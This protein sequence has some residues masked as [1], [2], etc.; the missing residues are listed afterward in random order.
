MKKIAKIALATTLLLTLGATVVNADSTKGQ[1]LYAKKLKKACG[2]SGAV[3]AAN[4]LKW[5][6]K[7]LKIIL[8]KR[9]KLFVLM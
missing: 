8:K 7:T 5:N 1:K 9:L 4:I 2:I 3:M 6:G